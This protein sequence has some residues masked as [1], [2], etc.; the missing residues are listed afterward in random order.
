MSILRIL[1]LTAFIIIFTPLAFFWLTSIAGFFI[2]VLSEFIYTGF[3]TLGD[4][5]QS[6]LTTLY[7]VFGGNALYVIYNLS[8]LT[9]HRKIT[10]SQLTIYHNLSI[11]IGCLLSLYL[12]F[13]VN[14]IFVLPITMVFFLYSLLRINDAELQRLE[15]QAEVRK[16]S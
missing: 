1:Y 12:T 16:K 10:L 13:T 2:F 3:T 14:L 6:I 5:K 11:L 9:V 7:V 15:H 8:Y 4:T